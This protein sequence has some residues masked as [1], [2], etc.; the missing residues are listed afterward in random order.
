MSEQ[1][2]HALRTQLREL[3][4]EERHATDEDIGQRARERRSELLKRHG[5][6]SRIR[7]DEHGA[8]L[9]CYPETWM[10][11][12][13]LVPAAVEDTD[14]AV[15]I[16]LS[17]AGDP[18]D[19]AELAAHNDAIARS[20]AERHGRD[21]GENAMAFATFMNNHR[22]RPIDTAGPDDVREFLAEYYPRNAWPS[23][24]QAKI[25]EDSIALT[26]ELADDA[27]PL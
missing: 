26:R 8:V 15:E 12:G 21:H 18:D 25:V 22:A 1:L 5:Y 13:E 2:P 10:A 11:D 14:R 27:D 3:A 19:W 24:Q 17:G 4:L 6:A 23:D 20:V 9:V 7:E 16:P